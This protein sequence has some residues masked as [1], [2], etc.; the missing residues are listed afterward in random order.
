MLVCYAIGSNF[1]CY[2]LIDDPNL[3]ALNFR[4][5]RPFVIY[6]VRCFANTKVSEAGNAFTIAAYPL[7]T[8]TQIFEGNESPAPKSLVLRPCC[9]SPLS[10]AQRTALGIGLGLGN[11]LSHETP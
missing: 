6:W 8:P 9:V 5:I 4:T 1:P 10:P 7:R 3:V 2:G 11:I